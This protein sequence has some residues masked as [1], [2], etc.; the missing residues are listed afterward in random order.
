MKHHPAAW[1]L[2]VAAALFMAL[3]SLSSAEERFGPWVYYAPYYYPP[4]MKF[5][6]RPLLPQDF[7]PKYESPNPPQPSNAVPPRTME[8][9]K[10]VTKVSN[11]RMNSGTGGPHFGSYHRSSISTP[12]TP[13][14]RVDRVNDVPSAAV[15]PS[16]PFKEGNQL[17][18][19]ARNAA[20]AVC[21]PGETYAAAEQSWGRG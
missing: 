15:R 14:S 21:S 11:R 12:Y 2:I 18:A 19:S 17:C 5:A 9:R 6:G 13:K 10:P 7:A 8:Q 20:N 16:E 4:N 1:I 3:P